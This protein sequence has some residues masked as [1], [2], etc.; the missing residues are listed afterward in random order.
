MLF[1]A[2]AAGMYG[3][4]FPG[5]INT[6]MMHLYARKK[7]ATLAAI[8]LLALVFEYL[9]CVLAIGFYRAIDGSFLS[10]KALGIAG[11]ILSFVWGAWILLEKSKP[12]K[13]TNKPI[14]TRGI[15]SIIIH[16]QQ[17]PFWLYIYALSRALG[18][19]ASITTFAIFDTLGSLAAYLLYIFGGTYLLRVY[20]VNEVL[21]QKI[22]G[23]VYIASGLVFL[24]AGFA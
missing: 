3:Y 8:V 11:C 16:P 5:N 6:L 12:L 10:L 21:L 19:I 20:N 24:A 18:H 22:V 2:F 15:I 17:I 9:Y 13:S 14:M 1:L 7:I 4:L 23:L